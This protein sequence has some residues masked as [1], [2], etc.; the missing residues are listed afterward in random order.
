MA[1]YALRAE[2]GAGVVITETASVS[3]E[4]WPYERAPLASSCA[5]GWRQVKRACAPWGTLV[6]AGLGHAGA[7]GSSAYSQEVLWGP[8]RVADVVSREPPAPL[9][10]WQISHLTR[11]FAGAAALAA[12]A[13][14]DGVEV[15][16]GPFSLLRQFQSALT[17]H[18][19]DRYGEDR[20]LFTLE[21]LQAVRA[22][23]GHDK[24]LAIRLCCDELAPWAGI[25][26][27]ASAEALE[28]LAPLVDLVTVVRGG[29]YS[30]SSYRPDA[31]SEPGFNEQTCASLRAVAAGRCAISLQGSVVEPAS[32]EAALKAGVCDLVEM[33]RAQI[34][35]WALV[36]KVRA[37]NVDGVRPC[38]LCNQGCGVRDVRN[39]IVSCLV[40]P[41]AGHET[42]E[43]A[44]G[45]A[46]RQAPRDRVAR[47][48]S[49]EPDAPLRRVEA[50]VLVVGG[51]PA[52]MECARVLA[53]ADVAV[54]LAERSHEL[55]G[56]L[57]LA[58][59]AAGLSRF[60]QAA[61]WLA[62][63][64]SKA[65]V[66]VA[67]GWEVTIE[68]LRSL[69]DQGWLV[70]LATGSLPVRDRYSAT[71]GLLL[72]G[73]WEALE[74]DR[75]LWPPGPVVVVDPVGDTVGVSLAETLAAE[76]R[77]VSLVSPDPVAGTLLARSGDLAP[78]NARLA[79]ANVTRHL[80]SQVA[81]LA[82]GRLVLKDVWTG[83]RSEIPAAVLV[84][85]G[86]RLAEESLYR[87]LGD[88]GT[89]RA[90][91]C[92]A[93]RGLLPAVLEGRRVALELLG[94]TAVARPKAG[95]GHGRA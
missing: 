80:R 59:L 21:V 81:D 52:G 87:A 8:S 43:P 44:L 73:A 93:P 86:H 38:L 57:K 92:V 2:G 5:S 33:T 78:A 61:D 27:S 55:G 51:G 10:E 24:L 22:A 17:N 72:V 71:P 79:R 58:G 34:A 18:R 74:S 30:T 89:L 76:G 63:A 4:D 32:A 94:G 23:L 13:G 53:Q 35:D 45:L 95:V 49:A 88:A 41:A 48:A 6:L 83:Q 25:T 16:S 11:A 7:Q 19:Q 65:G 1:Y 62:Q 15:D 70:V 31:H 85:C 90:G 36:A 75:G 12:E 28:R 60:A 68:E 82:P 56:A 29:P 42:D 14:A 39:P 69:K 77:R 3:P 26:P 91:D 64:A 9:E 40:D 66:K 46:D 67:T 84:D 37:G 54:T 50:P 20:L 47:S